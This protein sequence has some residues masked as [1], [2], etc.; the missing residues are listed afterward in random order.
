MK[1]LSQIAKE[2][3]VT[4]GSTGSN[5]KPF[6]CF[7]QPRDTQHITSGLISDIELSKWGNLSNALEECDCIPFARGNTPN[8]AY[9]KANDIYKRYFKECCTW[10]SCDYDY[11][12][13]I[14]ATKE[15]DGLIDFDRKKEND[16]KIFD[17]LKEMKTS[18]DKMIKLIK[19]AYLSTK[20]IQEAKKY[21]EDKY[22][23]LFEE[24]AILNIVIRH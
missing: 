12:D 15:I 21:L 24:K 1:D 4:I 11:L 5:S 9:E 17:L 20:G 7:V 3:T 8:E 6:F 16:F 18:S 23:I 22:D 2:C 19:D 10:I 14:N 13:F